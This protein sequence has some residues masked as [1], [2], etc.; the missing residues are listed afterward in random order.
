M[1]QL[2]N[3]KLIKMKKILLL[4]FMPAVALSQYVVADFIVLNDGADSDYHKLEKVWRVYHQKAVD[5]GEKWA[6]SVWKRTVTENDNDNAAHYVVFNNFS[7][8]EQRDNTM[9]NLSMNKLILIMKAG[10][11]GEMSSKTVDKIVKI[12]GT[13]KKEVRQ[14]ELEFIDATPFVGELKIRD[15]MNFAV[16][17]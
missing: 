8:K 4:F 14:Y 13:L 10:L 15:K 3:H 1:L 12:R 9:K 5:L 7:S 2:I 16:M 17:A 6:W 11:K